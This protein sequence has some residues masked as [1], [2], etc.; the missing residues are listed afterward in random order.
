[1]LIESNGW[2]LMKGTPD[3]QICERNEN[4]VLDWTRAGTCVFSKSV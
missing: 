3:V 4:G 1:M 2:T